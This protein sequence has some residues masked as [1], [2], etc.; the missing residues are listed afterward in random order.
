MIS[1]MSADQPDNQGAFYKSNTPMRAASP[2]N[3]GGRGWYRYSKYC[4]T[5]APRPMPICL[6]PGVFLRSRELHYRNSGPYRSSRTVAQPVESPEKSLPSIRIRLREKFHVSGWRLP[7]VLIQSRSIHHVW[8]PVSP[9]GGL[10][11]N[12]NG[13]GPD[14]AQTG[15]S[16]L[17][18]D[19]RHGS[20]AAVSPTGTRMTTLTT[21]FRRMLS[22][23]PQRQGACAS[24]LQNA[25]TSRPAE[26]ES[27]ISFDAVLLLLP[28]RPAPV[29]P[30][31]EYACHL[32]PNVRAVYVERE[33]GAAAGVLR[34]WARCGAGT[35]LVVL[36]GRPCSFYATLHTYLRFLSESSRGHRG[37]LLADPEPGGLWAA[38]RRASTVLLL[39]IALLGRRDLAVFRLPRTR[40]LFSG[41]A[42]LNTREYREESEQRA[43]LQG[44]AGF[45][46][47]L[48]QAGRALA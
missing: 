17:F 34:F 1:P 21:C 42:R 33:P 27:G 22:G 16:E 15:R 10:H 19:F 28:D 2:E 48:P 24:P 5:L 39:R 41:P 45:E 46:S 9:G 13:G 14:R 37:L 7:G 18:R 11:G 38:A 12:A 4:E 20:F 23:A 36:E 35:P 29:Q 40:P 32:T 43:S 8:S 47:G 3:S 31:L 6:R 44:D 25:D 26:S 30:A